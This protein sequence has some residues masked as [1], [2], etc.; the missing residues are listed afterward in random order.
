MDDI[1]DEL[2]SIG[3]K[4]PW[5]NRGTTSVFSWRNSGKSTE[6]LFNT[7]QAHYRYTK[8]LD[9]TM[10]LKSNQWKNV[11]RWSA[12]YYSTLEMEAVHS[13]ETSVTIYQNTRRHIP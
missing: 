3:R 13:S 5:P 7:S 12:K 10:P 4:L 1:N 6:Q 8:T 9:R 2:E 11:F